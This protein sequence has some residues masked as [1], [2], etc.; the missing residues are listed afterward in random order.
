M[1]RHAESA[2]D[3][4]K[5]N[6]GSGR[7][8]RSRSP[9]RSQGPLTFQTPPSSWTG[10]KAPVTLKKPKGKRLEQ[11]SSEETTEGLEREL[12]KQMYEQ[13]CEENLR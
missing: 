2:G 10:I 9:T 13:M 3:T 11:D 1:R 7:G 12:E 6:G 5:R 8:R 4:M